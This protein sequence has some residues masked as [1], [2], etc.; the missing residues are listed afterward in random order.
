MNA[1]APL[2]L[3]EGIHPNVPEAVYHADPACEPSVSSGILRRIIDQSPMHARAAHPRLNSDWQ[4]R[5]GTDAMNAGTV[6]HS[7]IL[8]TPAPYRVLDVRDY[9]QA[10]AR[11][12]RD[13][14]IA[15]GLIPLKR[16][17]AAD[18]LDT[19]ATI[20]ARLQAMPTCGPPCRLLSRM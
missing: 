10:D 18:L 14:T 1:L 8:G 4:D 9:K 17:E 3:S 7:M 15:D 16:A 2:R 5:V 19:G 12:L 13:Q 20:R 6:L 11:S